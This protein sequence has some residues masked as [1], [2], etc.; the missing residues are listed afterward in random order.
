LEDVAGWRCKKVKNSFAI[1][2][3]HAGTLRSIEVE[4]RKDGVSVLV[5]FVQEIVRLTLP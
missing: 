2:L 3:Y 5:A 1:I 4:A